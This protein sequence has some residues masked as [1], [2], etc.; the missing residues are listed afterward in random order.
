MPEAEA[1]HLY[2][3]LVLGLDY[4]HKRKVCNRDV[5]PENMVLV[6][7]EAGKGPVLKICDFGFSINID[8]CSPKSDVGTNGYQGMKTCTP[9]TAL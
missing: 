2:R 6:P 5:K 9:G 3:Q 4:C 7:G 1:Q 8:D